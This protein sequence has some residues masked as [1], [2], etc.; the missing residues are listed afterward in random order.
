MTKVID[1]L[2]PLIVGSLTAIVTPYNLIYQSLL[3]KEEFTDTESNLIEVAF[4]SSKFICSLSMQ[5][6]NLDS[7]SCNTDL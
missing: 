5:K 3:W 1:I 6:P 7:Y 4:F 2:S